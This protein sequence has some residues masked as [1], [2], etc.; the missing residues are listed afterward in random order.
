MGKDFH[1]D[2]KVIN[3]LLQAKRLVKVSQKSFYQDIHIGVW[4]GHET[5]MKSVEGSKRSIPLGVLLCRVSWIKCCFRS[6]NWSTDFSKEVTCPY[7]M[8]L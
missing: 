8:Y 2:I 1:C 3:F 5:L 6:E 4:R 7:P